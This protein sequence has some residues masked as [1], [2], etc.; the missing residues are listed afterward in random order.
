MIKPY[1]ASMFWNTS[2]LWWIQIVSSSCGCRFNWQ[3]YKSELE[4]FWIAIEN[5]CP[6][7]NTITK[8]KSVKRYVRCHAS[9]LC[10]WRSWFGVFSS[11]K[12]MHWSTRWIRR[13]T[14]ICRIKSPVSFKE[15]EPKFPA[16]CRRHR[17]QDQW[18]WQTDDHSFFHTVEK[19]PYCPPLRRLKSLE[20][21]PLPNQSC[22]LRQTRWTNFLIISS[23]RWNLITK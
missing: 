12:M 20:R 1:I 17:C 6:K 4:C 15:R 7:L 2:L 19:N 9:T 22:I 14:V 18:I 10:F 5:T 11:D 3:R 16:L 23:V 21:L 13:A 8:L